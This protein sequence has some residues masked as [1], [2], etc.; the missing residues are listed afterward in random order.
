[1]VTVEKLTEGASSILY[2]NMNFVRKSNAITK[3]LYFQNDDTWQAPI[4]H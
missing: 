1:M 4:H 2:N 3:I